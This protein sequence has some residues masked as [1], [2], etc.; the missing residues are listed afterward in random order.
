MFEA[1]KPS[2]PQALSPQRV[3]PEGFFTYARWVTDSAKWDA[4]ELQVRRARK[5]DDDSFRALIEE[6]RSA[7]VSTLFACGV[8]CPETA[9]DIAHR[10][11][12]AP[13]QSSKP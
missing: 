5:G 4:I 6:H 7:V 3:R 9:Q 13:G 2:S 8:R 10:L 11:R 1:L 12:F